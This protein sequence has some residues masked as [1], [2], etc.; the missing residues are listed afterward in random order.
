LANGLQFV[1]SAG[2]YRTNVYLDP[3]LFTA[4]NDHRVCINATA[5]YGVDTSARAIGDVC[6]NFTVVAGKGKTR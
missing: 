1:A 4:G 2:Q 3:L 5:G 6:Q